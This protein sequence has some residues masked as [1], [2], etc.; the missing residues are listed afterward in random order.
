MKAKNNDTKEKIE[1]NNFGL[2]GPIFFSGNS[3]K[4]KNKLIKNKNVIIF[5][6][7][8]NVKFWL[9]IRLGFMPKS[10]KTNLNEYCKKKLINSKKEI[11]FFLMKQS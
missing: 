4:I 9:K 3:L 5:A 11:S 1:I 6:C 8:K 7:S 2:L 10:Y